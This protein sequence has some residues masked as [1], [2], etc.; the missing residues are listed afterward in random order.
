MQNITI[1]KDLFSDKLH[2][3]SIATALSRIKQ[4][5]SKKL[6]DLIRSSSDVKEQKM[7]KEK[8][9]CVFFSGIFASRKDES[10]QQHSNFVILDF[11]H[12][13]C[14]T[15]KQQLSTNPF[16]Y[17]CWI[18]P[19]GTG[20]KALVRIADGNNHKDHLKCI[21]SD[22]PLADKSNINPARICFESY[23]ESIYINENSQIYDKIPAKDTI[24]IKN[25]ESIKSIEDNKNIV[26]AKLQKW[27]LSTNTAFQNGERNI[28]IFKLASACCRFGIIEHDCNLLI[29]NNYLQGN[30][31]FGEREIKNTIKSAYHSNSLN[32]NT[33]SFDNT[34]S[35][36]IY[37]KMTKEKISIDDFDLT[38]KLEDVF[39]GKDC[40]TNALSL[41]DKGYE[42][43]ET[44]H[45]PILNT[46]WKFKRGEITLVS[47]IGNYGKSA[48]L[49]Q[50]LLIKSVKENKKWAMF[51]P[52]AF[53]SHE[54]YHS[55]TETYLGMDCT[56]FNVYRPSREVYLNAYRKISQWFYFVYLQKKKSTPQNIREKFLELVIR[57]KVDGV[58][59]DPFNQLSNDWG[60]RDDKYL[61]TF[62]QET[63]NFARENNIF[64]F[65][66]NH[67]TKLHKKDGELNYPA[68]DVF[69]L[70]GG[71]MWNNKMDNIMIYHRPNYQSDPADTTTELHIKKIKR[72]RIVGLPGTITFDYDRTKRRFLFDG[73]SP[74]DNDEFMIFNKLQKDIFENKIQ[75]FSLPYTDI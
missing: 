35:S 7:L 68:P 67:P 69:N 61:E 31:D 27:L 66:V 75:D 43:A 41:Y 72:Q 33:A 46:H 1:F 47:G 57:E 30:S 23:D 21:Y 34:A 19:S 11:D 15:I 20:V 45:I 25:I 55:L 50:L 36:D 24:I 17:S 6:I 28:F 64:F 74:L 42:T 26:F 22:F 12:C 9:P 40:E 29:K 58:V 18:S 54:F 2:F 60:E 70:A 52:E 16:I 8:L 51:S 5:H 65:I 56:P 3:I 32:F 44:T 38:F 37:N 53:P 59:I 73:V 49:E 63:S 4:G 62:L 10:L 13:D 14:I 48:F 39:Y 71:A